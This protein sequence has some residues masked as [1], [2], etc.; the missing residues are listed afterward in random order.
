MSWALFV[1]RA[2]FHCSQHSNLQQKLAFQWLRP[3]VLLLIL[4]LSESGIDVATLVKTP[5]KSHH[6]YLWSVHSPTAEVSSL[7]PNSNHPSLHLNLSWYSCFLIGSLNWDKVTMYILGYCWKNMVI[8]LSL[9]RRV[10][11]F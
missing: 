10:N 11:G 8:W 3:Q 5:R 7:G 4:N 6:L 9:K 1:L 2:Y